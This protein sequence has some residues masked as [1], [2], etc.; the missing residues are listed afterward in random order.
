MNSK[1]KQQQK[2][3]KYKRVKNFKLKKYAEDLEVELSVEANRSEVNVELENPV[4]KALLKEDW[5]QPKD[6]ES[7]K[8]LKDILEYLI[9]SLKNFKSKI[10][11]DKAA[12]FLHNIYK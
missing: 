12:A 2:N 6:R 5:I 1:K 9:K 8:S 7:L 3:P 11:Y 10:Y 4:I